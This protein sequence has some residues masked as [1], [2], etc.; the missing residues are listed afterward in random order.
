M[1]QDNRRGRRRAGSEAAPL[2]PIAL[3]LA[4]WLTLMVA[5]AVPIRLSGAPPVHALD[6]RHGLQQRAKFKMH[7][8]IP[9]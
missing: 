4:I 7:P 1:R 2:D 6:D 8:P 5:I 9:R 3:A